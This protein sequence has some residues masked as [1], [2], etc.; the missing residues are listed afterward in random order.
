[1]LFD[2]FGVRSP[3]YHNSTFISRQSSIDSRQTTII[4]HQL[5]SRVLATARLPADVQ[6]SLPSV[7]ARILLVD[8][9][10]NLSNAIIDFDASLLQRVSVADGD[11]AIGE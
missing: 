9:L 1:M 4:N 5:K 3:H 11:G 7:R 8:A 6:A 2:A 10:R